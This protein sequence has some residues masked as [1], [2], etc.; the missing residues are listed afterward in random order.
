MKKDAVLY[1]KEGEKF[2]RCSLCA[3][4]CRIADKGFGICGVRQNINGTLYTLVYANPVALHVDPIEKKPFYHFLP[5]SMSYSLATIGCNFRCGFCQNWQI[6]QVRFDDSTAEETKKT[7]PED[8]VGKAL[9]SRCDSI[10]YTYTEPTIFLEYALDVAKIATG[11]GLVN[12]FV[13][14]GYMTGEALALMKPFI[15]A[16]N[17]DLKFFKDESYRKICGARLEPVLNSIKA[18]KDM[19]MWVEITT[20]LI[21]GV[22]DSEEELREMAQFIAGIDTGMPWHISRFH[23]DYLFSGYDITPES[24]LKKAVKIGVDAGLRFVYAGNVDGWGNDTLCPKCRK[25]LIKRTGFNVTENNV[26]QRKCPACKTA[27]PGMFG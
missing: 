13:T 9:V 15:D 20:L 22:N 8:I 10:S 25:V 7:A 11:R 3:H 23:P 16:A 21:P 26:R 12:V 18:M 19:G 1:L 17:V 5:G 2:V 6:S 4:R 14:N 24:A 27:I